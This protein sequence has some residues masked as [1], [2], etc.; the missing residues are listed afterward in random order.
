VRR[1]VKDTTQTR[2]SVFERGVAG[3]ELRAGVDRDLAIDA[4]YSPIYYRLLASGAP[5]DE[6]FV[7]R[8]IDLVF[9]GLTG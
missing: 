8:H 5:I 7:D 9:R 1:Y 2:E 6:A 4:L 3:G